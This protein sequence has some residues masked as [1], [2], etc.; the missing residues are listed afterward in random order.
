[1]RG[2]YNS[3]RPLWQPKAY[4]P[5]VSDATKSQKK[6]YDFHLESE[7]NRYAV[8]KGT[9]V[10]HPHVGQYD[11][12]RNLV[13]YDIPGALPSLKVTKN[14][15][16]K[17]TANRI[18]GNI[19]AS[20]DFGRNYS[21]T[22]APMDSL[23]QFRRDYEVQGT[24]R[25]VNPMRNSYAG[26]TGYQTQRNFDNSYSK[27]NPEVSYPVTERGRAGSVPR[28]SNPQ[29][30]Y[31]PQGYNP[32]TIQPKQ[33]QFDMNSQQRQ[34]EGE[35]QKNVE[36]YGSV[37]NAAPRLNS[38]TDSQEQ[39]QQYAVNN[40]G[41]SPQN[42]AMSPQKELFSPQKTDSKKVYTYNIL[43]HRPVP[44]DFAANTRLPYKYAMPID[45]TRKLDF[46]GAPQGM[47]KS[48]YGYQQQQVGGY[49]NVNENYYP[50]NV[51]FVN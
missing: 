30:D 8:M 48:G 7:I 32:Y 25:D 29:D 50:D 21:A 15:P 44:R 26:P 43:S 19:N 4:R 22:P 40:Q 3:G 14:V 46:S 33:V 39:Q 45:P 49:D 24:A 6:H 41:Y 20:Q 35:F 31:T 2:S 18:G 28:F 42:N 38:Q 23:D 1:M 16:V 47:E 51:R 36:F 34:L 11:F 27:P 12:P 17:V 37:N 9:E 5:D 10:V 13:T